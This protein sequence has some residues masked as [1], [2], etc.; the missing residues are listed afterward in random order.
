MLIVI[1]LFVTKEQI[2][3]LRQSVR[4]AAITITIL[5][6]GSFVM[7]MAM[8]GIPPIASVFL[9]AILLFPLA[10]VRTAAMKT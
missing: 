3:I 6:G 1:P 2:S 7:L 5:F 8:P 4:C 10:L 9:P